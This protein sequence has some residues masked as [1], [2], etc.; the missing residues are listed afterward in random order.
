MDIARHWKTIIDNI[1]DALLIIGTDGKIVG[2][3]PAAEA[4]TGLSKKELTG[5]TCDI[6]N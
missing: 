5:K 3:N 2:V 1:R 6:L 4:M